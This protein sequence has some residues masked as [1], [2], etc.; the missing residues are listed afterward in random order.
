MSDKLTDAEKIELDK[1]G[2]CDE[3]W[4]CVRINGIFYKLECKDTDI[5]IDTEVK[6]TVPCNNWNKIFINFII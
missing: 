6:V 3:F 1:L 2:E 5:V 4:Y